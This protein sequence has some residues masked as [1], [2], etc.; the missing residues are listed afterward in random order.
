MGFSHLGSHLAKEISKFIFDVEFLE[1]A[2]YFTINALEENFINADMN[3]KW[4]SG[5]EGHHGSVV[6]FNQDLI[7]V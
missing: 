2:S 7:T 3:V 1:A 6:Y 5:F 4:R